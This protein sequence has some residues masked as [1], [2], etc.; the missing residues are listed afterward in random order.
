MNQLKELIDEIM[1]KVVADPND[2]KA[3]IEAIE[4]EERFGHSKSI[5]IS[6]KYEKIIE[7][8]VN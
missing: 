7:A 4:L 6:D 5:N 2:R 3:L 8:L 1:K